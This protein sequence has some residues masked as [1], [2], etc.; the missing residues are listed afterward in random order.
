[1]NT[2]NPNLA[3]C[4]QALRELR[5]QAEALDL[6]L[7]AAQAAELQG[8]RTLTLLT[9]AGLLVRLNA[10]GEQLSEEADRARDAIGD[11]GHFADGAADAGDR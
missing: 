5:E 1:M 6:D 7:S 10:L 3:A 2:A 8:E 9:A 4:R 11:L